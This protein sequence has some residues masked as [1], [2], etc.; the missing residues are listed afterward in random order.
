MDTKKSK[1]SL[2]IK[3]DN[4]TN[5]LFNTIYGTADILSNDMKEKWASHVDVFSDEE[6]KYL[7]KRGHLVLKEDELRLINEV[8]KRH[9]SLKEK[10]SKFYIIFSYTCNLGCY[11]CFENNIETL[12]KLSFEKLDNVFKSIKKII[13][14]NKTADN[15]IVLFGGEPLLLENKGLIIKTFSFAKES[16]L[17]VSVITNGVNIEHFLKIFID[18]KNIIN[19][20]S[21]TIDGNKRTHDSRRTFKNGE[22]TYNK[23]L[24]GINLLTSRGINVSIRMNIDPTNGKIIEQALD[25]LIIKLTEKPRVYLSLV[26]NPNC[27]KSCFAMYNYLEVTKLLYDLGYFDLA[28]EV[29]FNININSIKQ[30]KYLL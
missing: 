22:P 6:R 25:E 11:Y 28:K 2:I 30:I 4:N 12:S 14:F 5:I 17:K 13:E 10:K 20:F 9:I 15:E 8:Q 27:S 21:I 7:T 26:E 3:L 16:N 19:S 1:Y 24:E 18:N 29:N 23:I